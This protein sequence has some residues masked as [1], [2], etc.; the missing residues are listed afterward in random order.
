VSDRPR[1]AARFDDILFAEDLA[2]ATAAGSEVGV[3]ERRRIEREGISPAELM[4]CEPEARDGTRLPGCVK[5]HLPQPAGDWGMV[6]TGD[7]DDKGAPVLVCLAFGRRHPLR[8]WQPSVYE[9]AHR[10]LNQLP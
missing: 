2:H 1:F 9:V 4:G 8:P 7:A 3:S 10:R 6:F 5:T